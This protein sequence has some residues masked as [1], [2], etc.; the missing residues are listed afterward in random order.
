V[1]DDDA[2]GIQRVREC[3]VKGQKLL[4]ELV[5]YVQ[6]VNVPA[7][8]LADVNKEIVEL[9]RKIEEIGYENGP[10]APMTRMFVFAK[11]NLQGSDPLALASQMER[12]YGDLG[13]RADKF[14]LFLQDS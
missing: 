2:A 9:D 13:R 5:E 10:L 11:E 8:K 1:L 3:A 14:R 7:S 12:I 6:D 4:A